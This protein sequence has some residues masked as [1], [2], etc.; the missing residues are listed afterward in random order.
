V[1]K[2]LSKK[3]GFTL[4]EIVLVLAIAGLILVV[5]FLA[6]GGANRANRDVQRTNEAGALAADIESYAR[7]NNGTYPTTTLPASYTNNIKDIDTNN[8]PV[9]SSADVT[10]TTHVTD[11]I[12][13]ASGFKC[14]GNAMVAGGVRNY[15]I[16]YWSEQANGPICKDNQ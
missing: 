8:A 3:E 6:V 14:N 11:G 13:Y 12:H 1:N 9:Y 5:V 16:S 4:I 7:N 10:A 2:L 15:A